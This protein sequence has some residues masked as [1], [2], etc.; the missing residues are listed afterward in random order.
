MLVLIPK[1]VNGKELTLNSLGELV[2]TPKNGGHATNYGFIRNEIVK[3]HGN[4]SIDKSYWVLMTQDVIPGSRGKSYDVQKNLIKTFS[5]TKAEYQVPQALEAAVC[6]FMKYVSTGTRMYSVNP[7]YTRCQE[8]TLGFQ[9]CFGG[10]TPA[11][12]FVCNFSSDYTMI[13]VAGLRKF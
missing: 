2:K 5:K 13:G 4:K 9:L 8:N 6:I 3:E 1:T 11:G 12:L 7:C 10:F